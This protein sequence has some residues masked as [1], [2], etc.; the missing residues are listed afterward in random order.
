MHLPVKESG[1]GCCRDIDPGDLAEAPKERVF[2]NVPQN[3]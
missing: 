3:K 1:R 2:F